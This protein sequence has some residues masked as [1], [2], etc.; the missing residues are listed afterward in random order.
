[1]AFCLFSFAI[2]RSF[3]VLVQIRALEDAMEKDFEGDKPKDPDE[4][5]PDDYI[6]LCDVSVSV[7]GKTPQ[8]VTKWKPLL[9]LSPFPQWG[10]RQ[11]PQPL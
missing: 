2:C 9:L 10:V 7:H 1:M 11:Q 4:A 8:Q 6:D 3:F 5:D